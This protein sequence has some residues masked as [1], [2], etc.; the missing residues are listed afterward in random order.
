[1][2]SSDQEESTFSSNESS[3]ELLLKDATNVKDDDEKYNSQVSS[4]SLPWKQL[5]PLCIIQIC[6]SFNSSSIF[7]Y[8][9]FIVV[10]FTSET[11]ETAGFLAGFLGNL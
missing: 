7:S 3:D 4:S 10:S 1:M 11:K 5:A 9:T 8:A 2:K 6:E